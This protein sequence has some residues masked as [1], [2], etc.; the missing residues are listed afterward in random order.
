MF[1]VYSSLFLLHEYFQLPDLFEETKDNMY[2]V[3]WALVFGFA[4][5]NILGLVFRR[6]DTRKMGLTFGEVLAITVV[7]FSILLLGL[8]MMGVFHILPIRLAPR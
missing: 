8:E 3:L 2:N 1:G 4:T 6:F 7:I 5:L